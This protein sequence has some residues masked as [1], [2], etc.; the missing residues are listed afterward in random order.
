M[1]CTGG[2]VENAQTGRT[3]KGLWADRAEEHRPTDSKQVRDVGS[4]R[5]IRD[6]SQGVRN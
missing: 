5:I 2:I 3:G 6:D 1:K 4:A